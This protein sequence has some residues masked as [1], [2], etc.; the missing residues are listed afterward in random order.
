[1]KDGAITQCER[2]RKKYEVKIVRDKYKYEFK[3][4]AN[5]GTVISYESNYIDKSLAY[6]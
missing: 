6:L 5:S 4:D 2:E 3:I 1:M